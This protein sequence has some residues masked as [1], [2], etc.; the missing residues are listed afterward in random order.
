M[1][2][3]LDRDLGVRARSKAAN[4]SAILK[5]A[6]AVFAEKGYEAASVRDVIRR[7]ELA[8]GTFYNY[9]RS[10]EELF[11]ALSADSIKRFKPRLIE[12]KQVSGSLTEYVHRVYRLY[13]E[14]VLEEVEEYGPVVAS[15][16]PMPS[17]MPMPPDVDSVFNLLTKELTLSFEQRNIKGVE[18]EFVAAAAVGLARELRGRRINRK[19]P[20]AAEMGR[21]AAS[22]FLSG[23]TGIKKEAS[24]Q[25]DL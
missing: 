16:G 14:F 12:A 18:P 24:E 25:A 20:D 7:T 13:F 23:F 11:V 3:Y 1:S 15:N 19:N 4:R 10:K 8:S 22:F 6:R 21:F 17:V 2:H 5:A 9:F